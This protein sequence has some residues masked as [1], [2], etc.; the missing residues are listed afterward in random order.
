[1]DN[2]LFLQLA[3][4]DYG[5]CFPAKSAEAIVPIVAVSDH[6]FSGNTIST[7]WSHAND[8]SPIHNPVACQAK[9]PLKVRKKGDS[10]LLSFLKYNYNTL[11]IK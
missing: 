4:I 10:P 6:L 7:S 2:I 9:P 8:L 5:F 3:L 1:M 11:L